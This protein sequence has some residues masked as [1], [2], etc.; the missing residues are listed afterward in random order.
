MHNNATLRLIPVALFAHQVCLHA[1]AADESNR[2]AFA[3][4]INF[5]NGEVVKFNHLGTQDSV[6]QYGVMGQLGMKKVRYDFTELNEV[7]FADKACAYRSGGHRFWNVGERGTLEIV[8]R[9]GTR[10][11]LTDAAVIGVT[12]RSRS[13]IH[14]LSTGEIYYTYNDPVTRSVRDSKAKIG[15]RIKAKTGDGIASVSID[16]VVGTMKLNSETGAYFPS[17]YNYDPYTG[18]PL[19]WAEDRQDL[20]AAGK[21]S[22]RGSSAS[23]ARRR[24][25]VPGVDVLDTVLDTSLSRAGVDPNSHEAKRAKQFGKLWMNPLADPDDIKRAFE[26]LRRDFDTGSADK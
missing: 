25:R 6:F 2:H 1:T 16:R 15:D 21:P 3:G 9:D 8:S 7:I 5:R 12:P 13:G 17:T 24:G 26:E 18:Q 4:T 14:S 10:F 20:E 19:T 23:A 22:S 11:T